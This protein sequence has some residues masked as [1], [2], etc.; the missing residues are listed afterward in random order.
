MFQKTPLRIYPRHLLRACTPSSAALATRAFH[1]VCPVPRLLRLH[2]HTRN[3]S[4]GKRRLSTLSLCARRVHCRWNVHT[5]SQAGLLP[6]RICTTSWGCTLVGRRYR[7]RCVVLLRGSSIVLLW[8]L[9]ALSISTN[10]LRP[11]PSTNCAATSSSS[12]RR[13]GWGGCRQRGAERFSVMR[14]GARVTSSRRSASR[15]HR[16]EHR[17]FRSP[18]C[19]RGSRA[20]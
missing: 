8:C 3:A 4:S 16:I 13:I 11:A 10:R 2:H 12:V 7:V 19:K 1:S 5:G 18:E 15:V 20:G 9:S 14:M 17:H 6:K